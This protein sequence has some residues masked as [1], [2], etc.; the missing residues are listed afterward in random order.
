[1]PIWKDAQLPESI[2][3]QQS[4]A[5]RPKWA[6]ERLIE[7][8]ENEDR[9]SYPELGE[10]TEGM[11]EELKNFNLGSWLGRWDAASFASARAG[12][13]RL[14]QAGWDLERLSFEASEEGVGVWI[15]F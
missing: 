1:M 15:S 12:F 7:S 3:F 6:M 11:I 5:E 14:E 9:S 4:S 10:V 8:W 13:E 2:P